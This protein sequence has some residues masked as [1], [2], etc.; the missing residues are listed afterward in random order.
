MSRMAQNPEH[1]YLFYNAIQMYYADDEF[2]DK[3]FR[4][5]TP[6]LGGNTGFYPHETYNICSRNPKFLEEY[7]YAKFNKLNRFLC[8][9][10]R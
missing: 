9:F 7:T 1:M 4:I 2:Q 5:L 8:Q 6:T 3:N 10:S